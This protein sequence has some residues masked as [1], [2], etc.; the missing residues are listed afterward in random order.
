MFAS[1]FTLGNGL[2]LLCAVGVLFILWMLFFVLFYAI[3]PEKVPEYD[4]HRSNALY[5]CMNRPTILVNVLRFLEG[6]TVI[7]FM[8]ATII[9][10]M[11]PLV[12]GTTMSDDTYYLSNS[13]VL[14]IDIEETEIYTLETGGGVYGTFTLGYGTVQGRLTYQYFYFSDGGYYRSYIYCDGVKIIMDDAEIPRIEETTTE[15]KV[16]WFIF[17]TNKKIKNTVIY[18]PE[19]SIIR[20]YTN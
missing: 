19:G 10:F 6:L 18:I 11:L 4:L 3:L 13:E 16:S 20:D 12:A 7:I 9:L 17:S 2:Y 8:M 14:S 15:Y 1:V 5:A